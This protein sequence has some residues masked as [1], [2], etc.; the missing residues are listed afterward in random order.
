[1]GSKNNPGAFDC[2]ANAHPDEPMFVLLGRD[3][4]A[5]SLVT[6]WAQARDTMADA[7]PDPGREREKIAESMTCIDA[8]KQW[9]YEHRREEVAV[10]DM[11]PFDILAAALRRRG[12][13][14]TPVPHGGNASSEAPPSDASPAALA[15]ELDAMIDGSA[16]ADLTRLQHIAVF[17][18]SLTL[19]ATAEEPAT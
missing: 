15:D 5:P 4:L 18:R 17:L 8:M 16:V 6:L 13:I 11:L 10:F 2:Y 7:R 12:A 14:V 1:M 19:V 9:L 3:P